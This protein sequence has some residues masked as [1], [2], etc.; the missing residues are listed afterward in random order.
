MGGRPHLVID[1]LGADR[2]GIAQN[3][4]ELRSLPYGPDHGKEGK[5]RG[6]RRRDAPLVV[7][8]AATLATFLLKTH[9]NQLADY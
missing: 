1:P 9:E 6:L 3:V 5:A 7:A 2:S 4:A 8:S